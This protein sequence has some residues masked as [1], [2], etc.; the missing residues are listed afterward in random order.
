M[1]DEAWESSD[2]V[3]LSILLPRD[4]AERLAD[5]ASRR[6]ISSRDLAEQLVRLGLADLNQ[7]DVPN[8]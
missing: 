8:A 5:E 2:V 1:H 6:E 7:D 3:R 4:V